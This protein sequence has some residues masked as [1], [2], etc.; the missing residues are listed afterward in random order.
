M[1]FFLPLWSGHRHMKPPEVSALLTCVM[2]RSNRS[3]FGGILR[4]IFFLRK[5]PMLASK[6]P[7][8]SP[9]STNEPIPR[10]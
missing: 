10:N 9:N 5:K 1:D 4:N 7:I 2:A 3:H 6:L 8:A